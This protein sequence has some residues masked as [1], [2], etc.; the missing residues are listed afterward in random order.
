MADP[1]ASDTGSAAIYGMAQSLPDRSIVD[2]LTRCYL[3]SLYTTMADKWNIAYLPYSTLYIH[4]DFRFYYSYT[5]KYISW[6]EL[7]IITEF[8]FIYCYILLDKI[9]TNIQL[10]F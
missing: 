2:Q 4:T 10:L 7:F 3:D 5:G 1:K 9:F 6:F 8:V